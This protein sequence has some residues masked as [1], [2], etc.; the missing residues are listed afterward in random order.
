VSFEVRGNNLGIH[1]KDLVKLTES[2]RGNEEE[3]RALVTGGAGFIGSHIADRLL[4]E[5]Y[6]VRIL[7]N[8]E[9]RVHPKGKPPW[10]LREAEFILGDVRDKEMM[11]R[12]LEGVQIV[13]H[14]AA[15]QDYMPDFSKFFQVNSVSTAL[16]QEIIVAGR[17]TGASGVEKVIVASSQAV[18]GEGQYHCPHG[19][20]SNYGKTT[21]PDS[22]S[23]E[24]LRQGQWELVCPE[25]GKPME[26]MALQENYHNPYNAYAISKLAEELAAVR[27]GQLNGIPTVALRYSIVQ[28]P[29][30]SLYNQYSGICRI[31]CLRLL[32]DLSPIIYEDGLQKRDYT[33]IDDVVEANW[34]VLKDDRAD[35]QVYNVGSGLEITVREYAEALARKLGKDIVPVIPGEYRQGDNRHSVS[36]IA[37]L[38]NLG[39]APAKGLEQILKDYINWIQAQG[40][41][42]QYFQAADKLMRELGVV[43]SI[44]M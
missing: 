23:Q 15:Y 5:G 44:R 16:I 1:K 39:W 25:C 31:F 22:R 43:Q 20:C 13:F 2:R 37:K 4:R 30:Q 40:D 27:L 34:V 33:H 11:V 7:D 6:E 24:Q 41:L 14:Q 29:R 28:G 3:M 8:L 26:N 10:L 12:A 21:Q 17:K 19:D 42:G 35:Y 32:N 38:K 9:P 18:Y 36:D